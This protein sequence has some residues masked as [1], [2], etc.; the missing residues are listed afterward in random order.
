MKWAKEYLGDD[1]YRLSV[2][3]E[4]ETTRNWWEFWKPKT[5]THFVTGSI[6]VR[7]GAKINIDF[8]GVNFRLDEH[9]PQLKQHDDGT[10]S[11]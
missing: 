11:K 10:E 1:W 3:S 7:A 9:N 4:T 2:V 6:L 8:M 5:S